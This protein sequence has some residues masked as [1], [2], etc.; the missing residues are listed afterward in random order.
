MSWVYKRKLLAIEAIQFNCYE[1]KT[2]ELV[3]NKNLVLGNTREL[4]G[5][6]CTR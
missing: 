5:E 4:D 1:F 2:L 3:K 6:L